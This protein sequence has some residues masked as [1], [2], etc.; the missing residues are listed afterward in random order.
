MVETV[1]TPLFDFNK[2]KTR[3]DRLINDWRPE[4]TNTAERR[5]MRCVDVDVEQL[6]NAKV[7]STDETLIPIRTI[8]S[9]VKK[10]QPAYVAYLTKSR[11]LA[12]FTCQEDPS[13]NTDKLEIAYTKGM[14]YNGWEQPYYKCLDGAQVHGWDAVEIE[15]SEAKPF[16]VGLSHVG[17]ENLIFPL[18]A[19]S[20]EDCE[21][22]I[23]KF[24]ISKLKL[25][26]FESKYGFNAD[27]VKLIVDEYTENKVDE[28]I[29]IYK[30]FMKSDGVVWVGWYVQKDTRDWLKSPEKLSLGRKVKKKVSTMQLDPMSGL[31]MPIESEVWEDVFE[32]NYPIKLQ[33]YDE[34]EEQ[35]ITFHRGRAFYDEPEQTAQTSIW[36]CMVNGAVRACNVYASPKNPSA[37]GA[38]IKQLD[39]RL[40]HGCIY[41]EPLEFWHTSYP[42][43][44]LLDI[45]ARLEVQKQA[46]S[47]QVAYGV[48]NR[49]DS[50]KTA[51]EVQSAREQQSMLSSVQVTLYSTF[52]REIHAYVWPIV[53]SLALQGIIVLNPTIDPMMLTLTY[54]V[55]PAGDDD[56][57][58]RAERLSQYQQMWGIISNTKAAGKYL[59][60]MLR[61]ALPDDADKYVSDILSGMQDRNMTPVLVEILQAMLQ[62]PQ[63]APALGAYAPKIQQVIQM[64]APQP[65]Q[66]QQITNATEPTSPT[67]TV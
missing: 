8:D 50:R 36:T 12:I 27:A 23:R 31:Q 42:D 64:A 16:K 33:L 6:Q 3:L 7:L 48:N 9:R 54:E 58:R 47:G 22:I 5:R 29:D 40:E 1:V 56:V 20:L 60:D 51:T 41:N 17:H 44:M 4:Q 61:I 30:I 18:K 67:P 53:Q 57:I 14:T 46:E 59:T 2:I 19:K 32:T 55:R 45:I 37:T 65:S 62:D 34:N 25:K 43:P 49:Q 35:E 38:S 10:E 28:P 24:T 39:T 66:P 11:R 13:I 52:L 26:T 63:I 15:Y 21:I